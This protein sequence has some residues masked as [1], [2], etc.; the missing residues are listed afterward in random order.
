MKNNK[1]I[2][3]LSCPDSIGIVAAITTY[4][5]KHNV[6]ILES[7]QFGDKESN[8]FFMRI[9][10]EMPL[11]GLGLVEENFP[12]IA[13]KF[14]MQ[15]SIV[16]LTYKPK[17]LILVS[18]ASHCLNDLL[19]RAK[20]NLELDIRAVAS[21]H[22]DLKE[23]SSWY[24][25]PFHHYPVTKETKNKQE[26]QIIDL[27]EKEQIDLVILA[28]YM[29]IMSSDLCQKLSGKA[30]NIHHSF[31]PSFK[32]AKP[33]HQAHE[34]GVKIIGATAHYVTENLDE[35]PIIAQDTIHVNHSHSPKDLVQLGQDT[36]C[37][38]LARAI[39]Y[40]VQRRVFINGHKTVVF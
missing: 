9:V 16:D 26:S 19:H 30:I 18:K 11:A 1:Y 33:Y 21:N 13:E 7:S 31:L 12:E 24:K 15:W 17:T 4:L 35:G 37:F 22:T 14:N 3:S 39:K 38:V 20:D 36:E 40:H 32:G 29:Q 8:Q 2:L 5:A 34:R 6:F 28:R 27:I 25:V 10:F 23:M